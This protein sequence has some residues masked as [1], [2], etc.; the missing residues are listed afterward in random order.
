MTK[1]HL[2]FRP[3]RFLLILVLLLVGGLVWLW[4]DQ[5]A[6]LR[7][8]TW[9]APKAL[10][11][12]LNVPV[13]PVKA[14]AASND[15]SSYDAILQ[16]P[17]FAPDRR[18]PPPSS[19]PDA[20]APTDPLANIH[21][22]GIFS[23]ENAGIIA[24]VENKMRRVKINETIGSWTLKS[25]DD[26]DVTF[27]QGAESRKLHLAYAQLGAVAPKAAA[28]GLPA[29]SAQAPAPQ[30]GAAGISQSSQDETRDRLRRLNESRALRGLPPINR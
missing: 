8:V 18:P 24:R 27:T 25:I 3:V 19:G 11:P 16:R 22:H 14:D 15:P 12:D 5:N 17:I 29:A 7:H 26:R 1:R 21:L 23:G 4:L 9:V 10:P 30:S 6:Q 28:S 13:S 2:R 20:T